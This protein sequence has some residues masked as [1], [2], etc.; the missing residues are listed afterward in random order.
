MPLSLKHSAMPNRFVSISLAALL[1]C[2]LS[3][4]VVL[5]APLAILTDVRGAVQIVRGGKASAGRNGAQLSA[6]DMVRVVKGGATV[7]YVTRPPQALRGGQQVRVGAAGAAGNKPSLWRNVYTGLS[8]GFARRNEVV[9]GATRPG[10]GNEVVE[11]VTPTNTRLL[12]PPR[13]FVWAFK[14]G[15]AKD[16]L[17]T[18]RD[19]SGKVL[20]QATTTSKRLAYPAG[21][22]ALQPGAAYAWDVTPRRESEGQPEESEDQRSRKTWF[23]IA[24]AQDV[25]AVKED[26]ARLNAALKTAPPSV[27]RNALAA[28]LVERGFRGA[29][30]LL[31]TGGALE[32]SAPLHRHA[33]VK[34]LMAALFRKLDE[35]SRALLRRLYVDTRQPDL[36]NALDG[37]SG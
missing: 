24:P 37:R 4:R 5:A 28:M 9:P 30:I 2:G 34:N 8:S 27:R 26:T 21:R 17:V 14:D 11:L 15:V 1:P 32:K 33:D 25:A 16:Y 7:F 36:A 31:L 3:A 6:G 12:E 22:A 20:W 13:A 10:Y 23:E 35:P 19:M 18:L 29:A